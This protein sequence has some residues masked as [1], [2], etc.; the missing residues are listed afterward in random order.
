MSPPHNPALPLPP[1]GVGTWRMG[2][3]PARRS[4]E[5]AAVRRAI[6]IG[7]RMIDTAEMYGEGG[8]EEVVGQAVADALRAGDVQRDELTIVS[9]VY[10][11][12][13]S[14]RGTLQ[15]C[16]RSC[17]RLGLDRIDLYLL[18]WRGEHAL[19]DT[20]AGM[21]AL[22]AQGRIRHW[23]VSNFDVEDL[24]ELSAVEGASEC[25]ANQVWYSLGERGAEFSLLPWLREHGVPMMA[26]SPID[27][28]R[29]SA[30]PGLAALAAPLEL[31]AAQLALAWVVA[32]PGVVAIPKAVKHDHMRDNWAAAHAVLGAQ[33]LSA[34]DTLFPPPTRPSA[35]AVN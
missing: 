35:L 5:V 14:R 17:K 29:L 16:E 10:P 15:A 11:H 22:A 3:S 20:V 18:H 27:Q 24:R 13:A 25:A 21:Q 33:T 7:Y 30:R 28:G 12:N 31:T 6:E 34:L 4:V 23:G 19:A 9:K 8:A 26:Y 2:E 32:Q 1:L